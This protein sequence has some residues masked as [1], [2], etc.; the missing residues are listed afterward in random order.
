V[1]R[2]LSRTLGVGVALAVVAGGT[3]SAVQVAQA[4]NGTYHTQ[5]NY[6]P[7]TKLSLV[8]NRAS[9]PV[10]QKVTLTALHVGNGC[11][12]K[13]TFGSQTLTTGSS[14]GKAQATFKSTATSGV[15]HASASTFGCAWHETAYTSVKASSPAITLPSWVK[16]NTN[17]AVTI[18]QFPALSNIN[19][20]VYNAHFSKTV[21]VKTGSGGTAAPT[22]KV[23]N[24]GSYVVVASGA[25]AYAST[26]FVAH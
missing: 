20:R 14:L 12:V 7:K 24:A 21:T 3:F 23:P 1:N 19:V 25:G 6:P 2:A 18:Y 8:A 15:I 10:T 11:S 4:T 17:F 9:V 5:H 26:T 22:F 16:K 13:F